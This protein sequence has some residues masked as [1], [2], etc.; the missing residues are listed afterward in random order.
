MTMLTLIRDRLLYRQT[1]TRQL[2]ELRGLAEMDDRMLSDIGID[3]STARRLLQQA[4][5]A[6]A[7]PAARPRYRAAL[8]LRP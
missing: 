2:R 5:D 8:G 1:R 3:R 6:P 4:L 7:A